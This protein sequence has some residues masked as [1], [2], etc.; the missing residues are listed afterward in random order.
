MV[1]ELYRHF[2]SKFILV[3]QPDGYVI[4]PDQ[5]DEEFLNYDYIGAPW[6]YREDAFLSPFGEHI[7]VGN[8]GFSLRSKKLCMT[9]L[10]V[11][12]PFDCTSGDFYKHFNQ[13]NFNE[14]G[15]IAVHN[16]HLF[17]SNGCKFAPI[18]LA[19]KFSYESPVPENYGITTF[20]FHGNR[21]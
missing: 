4:N 10:E 9:P 2:D 12:I 5:W 21:R 17:E 13:N 3:T 14:D 11:D 15:C 1:Y 16:R 7:R 20:G 8:G 18:E 19:A 6:P